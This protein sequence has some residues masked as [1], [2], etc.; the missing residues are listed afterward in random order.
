MISGVSAS[1]SA[2]RAYS[3]SVASSAANV[4]NAETNGYKASQVLLTSGP[5]GQGVSVDQIRQDPTPGAMIPEVSANPNPQNSL[6]T[7]VMLTQGS[8]T[9]LTREMVN[10]N[11]AQQAFEAN[12]TTIS[13]QD[14][15]AG[16][17]LNLS[18]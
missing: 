5:T 12:L 9:D 13:T 3:T 8:N 7:Q 15:M 18:A 4:A 17:V 14:Q 11:V 16:T 6:A 2:L 1:L 10:M